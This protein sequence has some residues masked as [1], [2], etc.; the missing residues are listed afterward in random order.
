VGTPS[1]I[2]PE[3]IAGKHYNP[4]KADVWAFGVLLYY[5]ATGYFPFR[6]DSKNLYKIISKGEVMFPHDINPGC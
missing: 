5:M 2:S 3:L 6:G 4:F 1:Y